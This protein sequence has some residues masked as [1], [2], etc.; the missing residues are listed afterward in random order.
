MLKAF[1]PLFLLPFLLHASDDGADWRVLFDGKTLDGWFWEARGRETGVPPSWVIENGML[2]TA[3]HRGNEVYLITKDSFRDFEFSFEW[4]GEAGANSGIKYRL[5][6]FHSSAKPQGLTFEPDP[7]A[8]HRIEPIGLEY[9]ITDDIG[10]RDAL[11]TP[12]HAAG[13]LYDYVAPSSAKLEPARPDVWHSSRIIARGLH[14]EHWLD[15]KCVVRVDLD[16]NETEASFSLSPR[17][18][19]DM[20]RR[21][22]RRESPLALQIHDGVVWFRNLR[23]RRL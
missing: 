11:S 15:G 21:Q 8:P 2:R 12:R 3:P 6:G 5:Q 23:I 16:S 1:A 14:I 4:K 9:Q 7:A 18:S 10:N 13:A 17:K 22:E 20:L 19:K